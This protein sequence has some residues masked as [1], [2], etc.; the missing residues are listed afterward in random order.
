MGYLVDLRH[1]SAYGTVY[2]IA[3]VAF[4]MGFAIGRRVL[5]MVQLLRVHPP[6]VLSLF[7]V[8]ICRPLHGRG[9]CASPRL[10]LADGHRWGAERGLRPAL[11]APA[12]PPGHG[13]EDGQSGMLS[14]SFTSQGFGG[15]KNKFAR[16]CVFP[17]GLCSA[18]KKRQKSSDKSRRVSKV[19]PCAHSLCSLG[20]SQLWLF[21]DVIML[22]LTVQM[23]HYFY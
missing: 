5:L 18:L 22:P 2:A 19:L 17:V 20:K 23:N 16:G 14:R 9:D 1:A 12:Q 4:C 6:G 3:D 8:W 7:D 13:G 15:I 21:P 10:P 11:L